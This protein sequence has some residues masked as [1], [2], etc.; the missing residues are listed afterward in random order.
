MLYAM[1]TE[2]LLYRRGRNKMAKDKSTKGLDG[3]IYVIKYDVQ[4]NPVLQE[5]SGGN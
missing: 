3:H 2:L 5:Q 1:N 4:G